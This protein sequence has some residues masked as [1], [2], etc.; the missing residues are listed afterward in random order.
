[1][2]RVGPD[3]VQVHGWLELSKSVFTTKGVGV[4][5]RRFDKQT[6]EVPGPAVLTPTRY[7][8]D[9]GFF[10]ETFREEDIADLLG[11]VHFVQDNHALTR[12]AGTIRGLH[13]QIPPAEQG[14]LV[15]VVRGAVFD[16][17]VDIR[18]TSPFF[19]RHVA[20]VLSDENWKQLWIPPGFAHGYCTLK[21]NTEVI[22][23]VTSYY[24]PVYER[25]L[26]WDDSV[27]D[28]KWPL[29]HAEAMLSDRDRAHPRL[30]DLPV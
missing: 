12:Q 3:L 26:A 24:S 15:R 7:L 1:M 16:V 2:W 18:R 23:K 5:E 27:L 11:V 4:T 25:G 9:R 19:G 20:V 10:S 21:P 14:K 8:D 6:Y 22:Y 13:Y 17:A 29:A 30:E 28:I